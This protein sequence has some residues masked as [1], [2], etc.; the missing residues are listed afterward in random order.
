MYGNIYPAN[1][2]PY[3]PYIKNK[4]VEESSKE[5][6]KS[7]QSS[8]TPKHNKDLDNN[9]SSNGNYKAAID[10]NAGKIGVQQILVDFKSTISAIGASLRT[11]KKK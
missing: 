1:I 9:S 6:E 8:Q 2:K 10:Y 11:F 4:P 7:Q 3:T 5:A